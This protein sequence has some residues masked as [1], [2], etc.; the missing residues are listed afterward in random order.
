M[1]RLL[2]GTR[3][4]PGCWLASR[5]P[6]GSA[7]HLRLAGSYENQTETPSS[8]KHAARISR[9]CASHLLGGQERKGQR[10]LPRTSPPLIFRFNDL[11]LE[12]FAQKTDNIC[13]CEFYD[14]ALGREAG[15]RQTASADLTRS[16]G[17]RG[18]ILGSP[19]KPQRRG[20]ERLSASEWVSKPLNE[21]LQAT[22]W[23][24][25]H[26]VPRPVGTSASLITQRGPDLCISRLRECA[27]AYFPVAWGCLTLSGTQ[28][29]LWTDYGNAACCCKGF[30]VQKQRV[31]V[32]FSG[33]ET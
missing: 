1:P 7:A 25:V 27:H 9:K 17:R 29:V 8:V 23:F 3:T 6:S 10:G 2:P 15:G 20:L 18:C 21:F 5:P 33:L 11:E 32:C 30:F 24:A 26:T 31:T 19:L 4:S 28:N 13:C 14:C 16:S 22:G 12:L